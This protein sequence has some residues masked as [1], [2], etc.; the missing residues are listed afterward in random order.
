MVKIMEIPGKLKL[1]KS[2]LIGKISFTDGIFLIKGR[3][4]NT[5]K[6]L[7]IFFER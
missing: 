7:S 3:A 1:E 2:P 6:K 5:K 4:L